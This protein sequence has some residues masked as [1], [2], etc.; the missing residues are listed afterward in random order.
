MAEALFIAA[1]VIPPIVVVLSVLVLAV[2][3]GRRRE[4]TYENR[5]DPVSH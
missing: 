1:C 3:A 5:V 4:R 2:P